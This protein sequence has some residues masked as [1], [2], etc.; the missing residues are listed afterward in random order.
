MRRDVSEIL[1]QVKMVQDAIKPSLIFYT[2]RPARR[3]FLYW[4]W[5]LDASDEFSNSISCEGVEDFE[6]CMGHG[7]V[8]PS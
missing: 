8:G 4:G 1:E 7:I 5:F 6:P 2:E 3:P